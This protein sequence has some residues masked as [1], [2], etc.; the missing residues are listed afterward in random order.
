M[1]GIDLKVLQKAMAARKAKPLASAAGASAPKSW[2]SFKNEAT[3]KNLAN[4]LGA[5][6]SQKFKM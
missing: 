3:A 1:A 2:Q 6:K 5:G 4:S